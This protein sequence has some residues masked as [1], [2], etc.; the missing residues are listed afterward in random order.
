M[1]TAY[2]FRQRFE[3]APGGHL[4]F[5]ENTLVIHEEGGVAVELRSVEDKPIGESKLISVWGSGYGSEDEAKSAGIQ[6]RSVMQRALAGVGIGANFGLR[7]PDMGGLV[8]SELER[9]KEDTGFTVLRDSWDVLVFRSEPQPRFISIF[10]E[11]EKSS[12]VEV[13]KA[14]I[15]GA[16]RV[17]ADPVNEVAFDLFTASMR[18]SYVADARLVLLVMAIECLVERVKRPEVTCEHIEQ[19]VRDTLGND[20]L[21]ERERE[22]LANALR[23]LRNESTRQAARMLSDQLDPGL[24]PEEPTALIKEAFDMRN[25]LVHGRSRPDLNRVRYVGANLERVVGDLIAGPAVASELHQAR[26]DLN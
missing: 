4:P 2:S 3:V 6:W 14:S 16:H 22:S 13:V 24:Y 15:A 9:I 19:L 7:N 11:V 26:L 20:A 12:P 17:S 25:A 8:D 21:D 18:S 1:P 5:T 23:S 10:G